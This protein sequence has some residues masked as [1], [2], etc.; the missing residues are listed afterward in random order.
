MRIS[1]WSSDVCSSDLPR[2]ATH[3]PP[4]V[5]NAHP[6]VAGRV[7]VVHNGI[8]ENHAELKAALKAGGAVFG[9]DT[10]TE[11]VAHLLDRA[12]AGG[13]TPQAAMAELMPRLAGA[14]AFVV[15]VAGEEDLL[16]AARRA[17]PL[18]I[19]LGDGEAVGGSDARSE[20]ST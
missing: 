5:G 16:I 14:F 19:G 4:T 3:G 15:L 11:V 12:I 18:A 17:S 7:A 9:S 20:G 8:I 13:L 10:D 1:Y 2:W 6:H